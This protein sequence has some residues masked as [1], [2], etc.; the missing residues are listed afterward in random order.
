[1]KG[2][3]ILIMLP[4]IVPI[5]AAIVFILWLINKGKN[6][7]WSGT[8]IDKLHNT[9]R[10]DDDNNV[11]HFYT[12]IVK[13]DKRERKVAVSSQLYAQFEIGDKIE[14]PKGALLPKKV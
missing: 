3:L 2:C 7:G 8:V 4:F 11:D 9:S 5:I 14:K 10:D 12:L 13:T 1:M 6:E